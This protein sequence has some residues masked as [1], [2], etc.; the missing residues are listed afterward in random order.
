MEQVKQMQIGQASLVDVLGTAGFML[1]LLLFSWFLASWLPVT[2]KIRRF[3]LIV[4]GLT[5]LSTFLAEAGL[6]W[7]GWEPPWQE[8]GIIT[9]PASALDLVA[10][11]ILVVVILGVWVVASRL[12]VNNTRFTFSWLRAALLLL[13]CLLYEVGMLLLDWPAP[14]HLPIPSQ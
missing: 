2:H 8:S 10:L 6:I 9:P 11:P 7:L 4:A 14:W 3:S 13:S 1:A 5:I 12:G